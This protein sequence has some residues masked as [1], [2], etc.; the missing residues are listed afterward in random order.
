M[1]DGD[2]DDGDDG[3]DAGE[4]SNGRRRPVSRGGLLA[5]FGGLK[6]FTGDRSPG[7]GDAAV[8][9]GEPS[10]SDGPLVPAAWLGAT[11]AVRATARAGDIS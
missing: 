6:L 5:A 1:A 9:A 10:L 4:E 7:G 8:E 11:G 2:G 3:D